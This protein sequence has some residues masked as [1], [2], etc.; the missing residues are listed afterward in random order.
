MRVTILCCLSLL[1]FLAHGQ[2]KPL[3]PSVYDGWQSIGE[4]LLSPD[5]KWLVYT[6]TPQE[7]DGNL[8]IRST[9]GDYAKE[10]PR[11]ADAAFTD[12]GRFVVFHIKPFYRDTREARIRKK[13]PEQS[14]K[15][16]LGW[17]E[18]GTDRLKTIPRV[19]SYKLPEKN[20]EWLAYLMEKVPAGAGRPDSGR[21]SSPAKTGDSLTRLRQLMTRADSLARMADSLNRAISEI[22]AKGWKNSPF[23]EPRGRRPSGDRGAA[24]AAAEEGTDLILINL[25]TGAER[26]WPLTKEYVFSPEGNVLVVETTRASGDTTSKAAILWVNTRDGKTDTILRGFNDVRNYVFDEKGSQ[27]AFVAERD[28]AVKALSKFY[29]LWYYAAG[30]DSAVVRADRNSIAAAIGASPNKTTPLPTER[31]GFTVSPDFANTFSKDGSRLYLGLAPIRPPKDTTLADFETARLDVWNYNDD[32]LAPAQLVRL[33]ADLK[34]SYLALL[35][36]GDARLVPLADAGCETILPSQE[37]DGRWALGMSSRNYRIPQQW[38]G[39]IQQ[40]VYLVDMKDGSRTLVQEKVRGGATLSPGGRYI[41]W[42]DWKQRGW[43][44]WSL[45]GRK[46]K[47]ITTG[48]HVPLFDEEDDHPDDPPPHGLMAWQEGDRRVYLYDKYDIWECD[49][50]GMA[51]PVNLTR[52]IGRRHALSFRYVRLDREDR[53]SREERMFP[54][55]PVLHDGQTI[56]LTLFDQRDMKAGHLL[57][58]MGT[59]FN[60]DTAARQTFSRSYE[61][62][63]KAR[64]SW[65]YAYL[66]GSY[67]QPYDLYVADSTGTGGRRMSHIN[68]QQSAYNWMTVELHHWKMLDGKMSE[69]LL[70]KPE[71]FDSTKKYPII[72]YFYE[73]DS[74]SLYNYIAPQPSRASINVAYYVSNGYLVFDPNIYYKTGQPGED[75]YNSVVSAAHYLSRNK[76]VDTA[77]MALQGHSWGGYQVA[78]L[79]TRTHLFAAAEAGAPVANMTSAYGGIRWETGVSRQ[80]QYEH[81]QSRIGATLWQQPEAYIRNSPLFRADKVTTPLLMMANDADGAVPWYQGIEYFSALRRLGKKTW[82]IEYNGEGHGLTERR[83]RKDWSMRMSQFF[84]Y[85]LKNEHAPRWMVEGVP[86]TLK[87]IDWGLQMD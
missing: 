6:V 48:I 78:Y 11:G 43:C 5:G 82:L 84:G 45:A 76:W 73:R 79:V 26:R 62:F 87:G 67:D 60:P 44:T 41:L 35:P 17:I 77:K 55:E 51:P 36:K 27:L 54:P 56:L 65:E 61:G 34:R 68:P 66:Q 18:L 37:G 49:P 3:D 75:A 14:P 16:S 10:I 22:E 28:S 63:L 46:M 7:G 85:Y 64:D 12:D 72:F 19:R 74:R 15:D 81:S 80:F 24:G 86:A 31:G 4:R 8:F 83:D 69:G 71:N 29:R 39:A 1:T 23:N 47:M 20:S 30:M 58:R 57:Y 42:Y 53:R 50:E 32:Y 21:I 2:K 40:H 59:P 70:Y 13:T 52:G 38:E 33:N 25:R 9:N